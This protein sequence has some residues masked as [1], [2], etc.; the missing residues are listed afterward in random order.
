[1]F[2]PELRQLAKLWNLIV[3]YYH[4]HQPQ[5]IPTLRSVEQMEHIC[6]RL[7]HSSDLP[8]HSCQDDVARGRWE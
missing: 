3:H 2:A 7:V 8:P 5:A 1:M 4:R 6:Q